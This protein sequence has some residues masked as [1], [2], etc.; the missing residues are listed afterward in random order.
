MRK[1]LLLSQL[2]ALSVCAMAQTVTIKR[3]ELAGEKIVVIYDL[4]DSNPN[5]EYLLNLYTSKDNFAKSVVAV[6]GDVGMDIKPGTNK[7]MEWNIIKDYGGYKGKLS[8]EIRGKVYVP[9][10]RIQSF[11]PK[12]TYRR[13]KNYVI[14]WKP[15]NTNPINIELYKSGQRVIGEVNHPNNGSYEMFIPVHAKTG[16]DYKLKFSD[17]RNPDEV[18]YTQEFAIKSKIP[19]LLKIAPVA[20]IGTVIVLLTSKNKD[21]ENNEEGPGIADPIFPPDTP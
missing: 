15:G 12:A 14:K 8:L 4:E 9:F 1:I 18:F 10:A 19:L 5:N 6:A 20:I 3:V 21:P 2:L 16:A 17:T 7:R 13:G 11:D